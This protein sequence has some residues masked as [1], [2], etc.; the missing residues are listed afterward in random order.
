MGWNGAMGAYSGA[1]EDAVETMTHLR[2]FIYQILD[3]T[4]ITVSV[5]G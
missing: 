1:E 5:S 3:H 4:L 2:V